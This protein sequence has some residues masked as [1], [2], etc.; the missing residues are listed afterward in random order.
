MQNSG[1]NSGWDFLRDVWLVAVYEAQEAVRTRLLQVALLGWAGI[2]VAANG[3]FLWVLHEIEAAMAGAL[4][5]PT[6]D[7]PGAML[8]KMMEEGELDGVARMIGG[9]E[10][11]S[12]LL[13]QPILVLWA[14]AVMMML[15][16]EFL[17]IASA[18]SVAAEVQN[19]AIR[20]LACRTGRLQIGLGKLLGQVGLALLALGIGVGL[21]AGMGLFLMVGQPVGGTVGGLLARVP[22]ILAF[23][24]PALGLGLGASMAART[25]S[26]ARALALIGFFG[27]FI[28]YVWLRAELRESTTKGVALWERLADMAMILLFPSNWTALW[29]PEWPDVLAAVA[30]CAIIGAGCFAAGMAVFGRR[31]L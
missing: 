18:A 26:G 5:V 4:G 29:S 2:V 12:F 16:P 25:V 27:S 20:Y 1:R 8:G 3:L 24:L 30:R 31:D 14:G 17:L 22:A 7:R 19:R 21:S 6:T 15:L 10:N 28:T 11:V 23:S 13:Q 9:S